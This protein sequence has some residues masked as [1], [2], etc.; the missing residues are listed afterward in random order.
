VDVGL[1]DSL[2]GVSVGSPGCLGK[3]LLA[4]GLSGFVN[5]VIVIFKGLFAVHD[6]GAGLVAQGP[7]LFN[8]SWQ[9][10]PPFLGYRPVHSGSRLFN[11]VSVG[12]RFNLLG[13]DIL[14]PFNSKQKRLEALYQ[15][16]R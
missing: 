9:E 1:N 5:V 12:D 8:A 4:Q 11:F 16:F 3:A 13:K 10:F 15:R 6:T 2:G 7:D 14:T